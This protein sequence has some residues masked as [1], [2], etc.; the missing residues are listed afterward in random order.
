ME[1]VHPLAIISSDVAGLLTT[2]GRVRQSQ[3]SK[4]PRQMADS[5]E[6]FST[7]PT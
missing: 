1:S 2:E 3:Q 7:M 6:P 5:I 4:V